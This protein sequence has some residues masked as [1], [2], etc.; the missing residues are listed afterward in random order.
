MRYLV[1]FFMSFIS[2]TVTAQFVIEKSLQLV[3]HED[4]YQYGV[5]PTGKQGVIFFNEIKNLEST[6]KRN[7]EIINLD[8][9]LEMKW[10]TYFES[11]Y[12]LKITQVKY[13]D[14]Y[15]Y[16]MFKDLNI[17]M[18][19]VFFARTSVIEENFEFFEIKDF[20]PAKIIGF[21]ILGN[22]LFLI[23]LDEKRPAI[24]KFRYGDSR[25]QVLRG[26]YNENNDLLH[27]EVLPDLNLIQI[28]TRMKRPRGRNRILLV[29]QFD[30]HGDIHKDIVIESN[31][32]FDLIDA[33]VNTDKEGNICIVGT[34]SNGRNSDY[35][36]GVFTMVYDDKEEQSI[37][38]YEYINL[39]RFF[40]YLPEKEQQKIAR[41]YK[42]DGFGNNK[43]RYTINHQLREIVKTED[44]W[45]YMGELVK[46]TEK[47]SRIY[48]NMWPMEYRQYSHAVV[49]GIAANG[50]LMWDNS[51]SLDDH[52]TPYARQQVFTSEYEDQLI[53]YY[54][55][56][57]NLMYKVIDGGE[58]VMTSGNFELTLPGVE[59]INNQGR[60]YGEIMPWYDNLFIAFGSISTASKFG[61]GKNIFYLNKMKISETDGLN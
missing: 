21:E 59:K 11:D 44:E 29:K 14:G 38:Y 46:F 37:Y 24:L 43:S 51:I 10:K 41:K 53:V 19:S 18:K 22:S 34:Y 35:S 27:S 28:V 55:H 20:L 7:W 16:L 2:P 30:Q 36:N 31:K 13:Y 17:P 33:K 58:D 26:L 57:L 32:G 40:E 50:R 61:G 25:P 52:E 3:L 8:S 56:G 23:G 39:H 42:K 4:D 1:L 54:L 5:V 9:D 15:L 49:L 48:G 47:N 6:S 60:N 12:N 45:R